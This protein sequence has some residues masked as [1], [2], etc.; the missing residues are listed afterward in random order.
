MR[1]V[2][3]IKLKPYG[4]VAKHKTRLVSRD[5]IQN[6]DIDYFKVVEPVARH[7][8]IRLVIIISANK[9]CPLIHLNVKLDFLNGPLQ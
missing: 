7:E 1:R 3:K 6:S 5:F 2:F 4:S 9:N 8:T